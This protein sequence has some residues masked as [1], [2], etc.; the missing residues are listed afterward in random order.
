MFTKNKKLALATIFLFLSSGTGGIIYA[1]NV[2]LTQDITVYLSGIKQE[3]IILSDS[4]ALNQ[5][6]TNQ[7]GTAFTVKVGTSGVV[8]IKSTAKVD[9]GRSYNSA[10][11]ALAS[12]DSNGSLLTISANGSASVTVTITPPVDGKVCVAEGGGG[13]SG[14]VPPVVVIEPEKPEPLEFKDV[15]IADSKTVF[16]VVDLMLAQKTYKAP[17]GKKFGVKIV[18]RGGFSLQIWNALAG[19]GCG[20]AEKYPGLK[21]CLETA[22][23][24]KL[25]DDKFTTGEKITRLK[26]YEVL[27]KTRD[28]K[29][30]DSTAAK[31]RRT[32]RGDV[33]ASSATDQAAKVFFTAKKY[34]IAAVY[35]GS[36]CQLD[37]PFSRLEAAKFAKRAMAVA[38]KK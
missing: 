27:L 2:K 20:D 34:G 15:S 14:N 3:Y 33:S 16:A 7:A 5:I 6:E 26:N 22:F 10:G 23:T 19:I 29:L 13:W 24:A 18:T 21:K 38:G 35:K 4:T 11:L 1:Q 25:V 32:C 9:I 36:K 17:Y 31:L 30:E 12:C 28:I 8:K 37:K